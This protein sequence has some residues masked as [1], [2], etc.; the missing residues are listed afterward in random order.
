MQHPAMY[1]LM[2]LSVALPPQTPFLSSCSVH[3]LVLHCK[4]PYFYSFLGHYLL[5]LP[6]II[7]RCNFLAISVLSLHAHTVPIN[8][9]T[10][11]V[12]FFGFFLFYYLVSCLFSRIL[13]FSRKTYQLQVLYFVFFLHSHI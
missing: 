9:F 12:F 6:D 2:Q 8:L 3:V 11:F 5:R 7:H 4:I 13:H 10:L 1:S